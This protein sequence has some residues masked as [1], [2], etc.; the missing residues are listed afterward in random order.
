M[1]YTKKKTP[2]THVGLPSVFY[3]LVQVPFALYWLYLTACAFC[4]RR[5]FW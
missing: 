1:S 4:F 5:L 2:A 3:V